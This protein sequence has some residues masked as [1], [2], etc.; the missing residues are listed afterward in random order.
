MPP[1]HVWMPNQPQ[2]TIARS[3]AGTFAPFV[4]KLA[5]HRTGNETPYFVPACALRIIGMRTTVL[6]SRMVIIACHQFIPCS[7]KPPASV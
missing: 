3:S 7:M 1:I 5:R 6:P 4:P 2:A